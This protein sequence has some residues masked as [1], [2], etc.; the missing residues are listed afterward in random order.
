MQILPCT[1][2]ARQQETTDIVGTI[3]ILNSLHIVT[4]LSVNSVTRSCIAQPQCRKI[5]VTA[6]FRRRKDK[7]DK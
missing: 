3:R 4:R 7:F 5:T 2:R 1:V 6:R